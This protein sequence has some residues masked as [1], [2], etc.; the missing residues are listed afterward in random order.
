MSDSLVPFVI[1]PALWAT[2]PALNRE[3][4]IHLCS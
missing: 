1:G 4:P 3:N 2:M